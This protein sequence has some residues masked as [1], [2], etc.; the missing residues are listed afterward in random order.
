MNEAPTKILSEKFV[1]EGY[2]KLQES[3]LQNIRKETAQYLSVLMQRDAVVILAKNQD[4]RWIINR[5]YRH[6]VKKYVWG[7][8]GGLM[9]T[10]EF[11]VDSAKREFLEE[12]GYKTDEAILLGSAYPMPSICDQKIYY[13][14]APRATKVQNPTLEPFEFIETF[15]LTDEELKKIFK[16]DEVD[17]TLFTALMYYQHFTF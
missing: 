16:S 2:F 4:G 6:P 14:Y 10:K 12:T 11:A 3:Q 15:L 17:S 9:E 1:Y 7:L 8:P 5:E 13:L